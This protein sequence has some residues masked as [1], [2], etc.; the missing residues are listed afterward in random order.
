MRHHEKIRARKILTDWLQALTPEDRHR[1]SALLSDLDQWRLK[2]VIESGSFAAY[3]AAEKLKKQRLLKKKADEDA[4]FQQESADRQRRAQAFRAGRKG[5]IPNAP[6][7]LPIYPKL[8][9]PPKCV[10]PERTNCNYDLVNERCEFME[11][12]NGGDI[13]RGNWRCSASLSK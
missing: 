2:G 5:Y 10:H 8:A 13:G 6:S 4:K 9:E 7:D 12:F 3:D 1:L 11:Y